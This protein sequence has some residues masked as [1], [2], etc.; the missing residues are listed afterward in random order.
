M[1]L[2]PYFLYICKKYSTAIRVDYATKSG[3]DNRYMSMTELEAFLVEADKNYQDE[4]AGELVAE[5]LKAEMDRALDAIEA[6]TAFRFGDERREFLALT[7][8]ADIR[9][10]MYEDGVLLKRVF[11]HVYP[12]RRYPDRAETVFAKK[13][14]SAELFVYAGC[15][16]QSPWLRLPDQ[17][18]PGVESIDF[19]SVE[20][21]VFI[22]GALHD[23]VAREEKKKKFKD[24]VMRCLT[25]LI[26]AA[27]GTEI[28]TT[29]Y[30][31][32][33]QCCGGMYS[34]SDSHQAAATD[35]LV[36]N[37]SLSRTEVDALKKA[38]GKYY[39]S[40]GGFFP[41]GLL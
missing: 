1:N 13:A 34:M 18:L 39:E 30:L 20:D 41:V 9:E 23:K 12:C 25:G 11:L 3:I 27:E 15:D 22:S 26:D 21:M 10:H 33:L 4:L 19:D 28:E 35:E 38:Y 37:T 8:E 17:L 36:R 7:S 6:P 32:A 16:L 40:T 2:L 29:D 5:E 31:Q 24:V 14:L